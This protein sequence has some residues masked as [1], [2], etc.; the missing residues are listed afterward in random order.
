MASDD[1]ET[2]LAPAVAALAGESDERSEKTIPGVKHLGRGQLSAV[3]YAEA[4]NG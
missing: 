2:S 4:W 1:V 3:N